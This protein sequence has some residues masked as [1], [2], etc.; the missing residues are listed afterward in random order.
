MDEYNW[1]AAR[2]ACNVETQ[3]NE[4]RKVVERNVDEANILPIKKRPWVFQVTTDYDSQF[5]VITF[6]QGEGDPMVVPWITFKQDLVGGFSIFGKWRASHDMNGISVV[7]K[8]DDE[9][10]SCTFMV[11]DKPHELWEIS[12]RMLSPLFF[13]EIPSF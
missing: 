10:Q 9:S 8:W 5:D 3:F 4:L 13:E 7:V 6:N 1:V 2:G 11:D 12:Q